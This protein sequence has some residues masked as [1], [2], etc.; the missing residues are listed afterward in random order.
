MLIVN[1][2]GCWKDI[3]VRLGL[4]VGKI[5][6]GDP[7]LVYLVGSKIV[8]LRRFKQDLRER[9]LVLFFQYATT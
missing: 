3:I 7:G 4:V 2:V 1:G 8:L 9:F 6:G 5:D